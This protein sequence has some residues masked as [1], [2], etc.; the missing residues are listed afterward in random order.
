MLEGGR[1]GDYLHGGNDSDWLDGGADDDLL[2]GGDDAGNDWLF[3]LDGNDVLGGGEG[4]NWIDPGNGTDIVVSDGLVDNVV[5]SAIVLAGNDLDLAETVEVVLGH[6]ALDQTWKQM[7]NVIP[8]QTLA[9]MDVDF[10]A[11]I[12]PFLE[13]DVLASFLTHDRTDVSAVL[14]EMDPS[15]AAT[16]LWKLSWSEYETVLKEAGADLAY[17]V[18][19]ELNADQVNQTFQHL[20]DNQFAADLLEHSV[21]NGAVQFAQ[22]AL[23]SVK[24][25]AED[26][27]NEVANLISEAGRVAILT[28]A[29][30]G[31]L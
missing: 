13:G 14:R 31:N 7:L 11:R 2:Y 8:V 20:A 15:V 1:G 30:K 28:D 16:S 25:L 21:T 29:T 27:A 5:G 9:D 26:K 10:Q 18:V 19:K 3:G 12:V 23:S 17:E 22:D 6:L 4:N 24:T